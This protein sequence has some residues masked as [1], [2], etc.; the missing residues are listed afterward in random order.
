MILVGIDSF[1]GRIRIVNLFIWWTRFWRWKFEKNVKSKYIR[2][3]LQKRSWNQ[4]LPIFSV[5]VAGCVCSRDSLVESRSSVSSSNELDSE[6]GNEISFFSSETGSG[7]WSPWWFLWLWN[8]RLA[9]VPKFLSQDSHL[10][11]LTFSCTIWTCRLREYVFV[12]DLPHWSHLVL[13]LRLLETG[14]LSVP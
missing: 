9:A 14:L 1:V 7:T 11:G 13:S 2:I 4:I 6:F 3:R 8:W 10:N 5:G 12:N